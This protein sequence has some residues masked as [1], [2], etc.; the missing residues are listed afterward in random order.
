MK[1]YLF[2][3]T[4]EVRVA[5]GGEW[6]MTNEGPH[7]GEIYQAESDCTEKDNILTR[8]EIEIPDYVDAMNYGFS[9]SQFTG[10]RT[11]SVPI[12]RPKKKVKKWLWAVGVEDGDVFFTYQIHRTEDEIK[13]A[14]KNGMWYHRIDK[15]EIEVDE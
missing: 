14:Y 15:T 8:H 13:R 3:E 9:N 2:I 10:I 7:K 6:A 5:K 12:P 1:A 4:G 11:G